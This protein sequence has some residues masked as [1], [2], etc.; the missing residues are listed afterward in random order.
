MKKINLLMVGMMLLMASAIFAQTAP[1]KKIQKPEDPRISNIKKLNPP[2]K[3]I[4]K[5]PTRAEIQEAL[6][7]TPRGSVKV[8]ANAT[9]NVSNNIGNEKKIGNIT[10]SN[11]CPG[12]SYNMDYSTTEFD[13]V[14]GLVPMD[15]WLYPGVIMDVKSV[16]DGNYN[17]KVTPRLPINLSTDATVSKGNSYVNVI[18]PEEIAK[19]NNAVNNLKRMPSLTDA[20]DMAY[21]TKEIYSA[22]DFAVKVSG[23]YNNSLANIKVKAEMSF[24]KSNKNNYL[25]V[26]FSQTYFSIVSDIINTEN[27]FIGNNDNIDFSNLVYIKAVKYGRR[28]LLILESEYSH[29]EIKAAFSLKS[30]GMINDVEIDASLKSSQIRNSTKAKVIFYGGN[31][32]DAANA[33]AVPISE[34]EK[35]FKSYISKSYQGAGTGNAKP[36]GYALRYLA[37]DGNLCAI[38]TIY[39]YDKSLCT[40]PPIKMASYKLKVTLTDIQN[41]NGRDGGG[42]NPD[43][44]AIQQYIVYNADKKDKVWI[45]QEINTFPAR[46]NGPVQVANMK[47]VLISGDAKNQLHIRQA[48]EAINRNRSIANSLVFNITLKEF[49]DPNA[50]FKIYT[51]FKEYTNGNDKVLA[52]NTP[53]SVNIKEVLEIL[54]GAKMINAKIPYYDTTI[55][56]NVKFHNFGAGNMVLAHIQTDL[57]K[58][59]LEGPIRIGEPGEK[60]AVWLQ[61]ELVD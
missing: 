19:L 9:K 61:F 58:L 1:I 5:K 24:E 48:D 38:R 46:K 18:K 4:Y 32:K 26:D 17:V 16:L 31:A 44:Y 59:V 36:I 57:S 45:S 43:D 21:T 30:H 2:P 55:A 7:R 15:G 39:N 52:N 40:P 8:N 11:G 33:V 47:N 56:K 3:P 29:Q 54:S 34:L 20:A 27:A 35:G 25:L 53:I 60:A 10:G 13:F 49:M 22:E 51:W 23:Y 14:G 28:A 42:S 6:Y 37:N 50:K 12:V 41:I